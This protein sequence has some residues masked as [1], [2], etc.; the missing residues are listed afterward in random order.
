MSDATYVA[1]TKIAKV[2][3]SSEKGIKILDL[4]DMILFEEDQEQK[5]ALKRGKIVLN[6]T[7]KTSEEWS[8]YKHYLDVDLATLAFTDILNGMFMPDPKEKKEYASLVEDFRGGRRTKNTPEG[9][10]FESRYLSIDR[11]DKL[12]KMGP[13]ISISFRYSEGVEGDKGQVN[14]KP[15]GTSYRSSIM[16]SISEARR[17]ATTVLSYIQGKE[18]AYH[19]KK[20][21]SQ[22]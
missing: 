21:M 10:E 9:W 17:L 5:D 12:T 19:V 11:T 20:M 6:F 18:I 15:G 13:A 1:N 4:A 3:K 14:P 16:L 7:D 22:S 8:Q 2:V